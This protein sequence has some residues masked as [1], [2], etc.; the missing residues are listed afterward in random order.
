MYSHRIALLYGYGDRLILLMLGRVDYNICFVLVSYVVFCS[1]STVP[2]NKN[3]STKQAIKAFVRLLLCTLLRVWYFVLLFCT[4]FRIRFKEYTFFY[5]LFYCLCYFNC[6]F[7]S[8]SFVSVAKL[9][10]LFTEFKLS[11]LYFSLGVLLSWIE[12]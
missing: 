2:L 6:S 1:F 3:T 7:F 8:C 5:C 9:S 12:L 11:Y 10:D 4:S